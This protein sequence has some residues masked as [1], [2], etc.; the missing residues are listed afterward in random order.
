MYR[1]MSST[2]CGLTASGSRYQI[3]TP[4][5]GTHKMFVRGC[6]INGCAAICREPMTHRDNH[7]HQ[8]VVLRKA[9]FPPVFNTTTSGC[10]HCFHVIN[11]QKDCCFFVVE[12]YQSS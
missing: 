10:G 9:A 1:V 11:P 3:H 6:R 5:A 8:I 7:A 2:F 12:L 4:L